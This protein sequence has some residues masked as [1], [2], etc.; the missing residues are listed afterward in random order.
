MTRRSGDALGVYVEV[1][2][3]TSCGVP[4]TVAPEIFEKGTDSCLVKRQPQGAT[5]LRRVL[6]VFRTQELTCIRYGGGDPRAL[7]ILSD[8]KCEDQCD[9]GTD[10]T[11]GSPAT[12]RV[13]RSRPTGMS[14]LLSLAVLAS[15]NSVLAVL[16]VPQALSSLGWVQ[17]PIGIASLYFCWSAYRGKQSGFRGLVAL[18]GFN[19][20]IGLVAYFIGIQRSLLG[21]L[22]FAALAFALLSNRRWYAS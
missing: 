16:V 4:W 5:E 7:S 17:L 15:V 11:T 19:V 14:S 10:R 3:C 6:R 2:C 1:D 22:F 8:V 12:N 18:S 13:V 21:P 20:L 9:H